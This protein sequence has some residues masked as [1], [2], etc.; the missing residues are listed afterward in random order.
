[1]WSQAGTL[2]CLPGMR[3]RGVAD[4]AVMAKGG[5]ACRLKRGV[6]DVC[7]GRNGVGGWG[8]VAAAVMETTNGVAAA[9]AVAAG[10]GSQVECLSH[11]H[12][13]LQ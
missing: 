11:Y 13:G 8:H 12:A 4:T 10:W 7:G 6:E 2:G 5:P 1:M 9:V 3:G